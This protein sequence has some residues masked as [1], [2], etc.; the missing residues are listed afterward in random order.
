MIELFYFFLYL[1]TTSFGGPLV[2]IQQMRQYF[3]FKNKKISEDEFDQVFALIKAMPGPIAFQMSV[4]L[5]FKYHKISGALLAGLGLILPSFLMMIALGY[6]YSEF[7]NIAFV[8]PLLDGFL[9]SVSAVILMSLK[10]LVST[11]YKSFI[12]VPFVI[13]NMWLSWKQILPEPVLIV[14]FGLLAVLIKKNSNHLKLFSVGFLVTDGLRI[15]EIFKIGLVSG[16]VVFGTGLALIPVLKT[17][18]VDIHHWITL[19]EFSDGVIFG[20]MSPGPI[21]ITGAF[22]GFEA[23]GIFG[24]LALTLGIHLMPFFHIVTW[25]PYAVKWFSRQKWIR[26]FLLGAT[27]AVVAGILVTLISIN[28]ESYSKIMFWII[29]V[30]SLAVLVLKPKVP[31]ILLIL[32]AGIMNLIY[33][34]S[35]MNSI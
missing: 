34:F 26:D 22:L 10:S 4:Y 1:G 19:K 9:F 21:T 23:A 6:F 11:Y 29:F 20:Q 2:L 13:I 32:S 24:A 27:S 30:L 3:V 18:L 15:Y 28:I 8:H 7:S 35:T 31:I 5:G 12:F 17:N 14:G 16:A 25:F 33:I